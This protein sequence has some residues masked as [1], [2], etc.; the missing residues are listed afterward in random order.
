M[1]WM[2]GKRAGHSA[3]E[4]AQG[5]HD[6]GQVPCPLAVMQDQIL[7][8]GFQGRLAQRP[9]VKQ[10]HDDK[11]DAAA[12]G[13]PPGRQTYA[14]SQLGRAYRS[15]APNNG[16]GNTASH[17]DGTAAASTQ[18]ITFGCFNAAGGVNATANSHRNRGYN[19]YQM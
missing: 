9:R 12:Q 10:A 7:G 14:I 13:K 6:A 1:I 2:P 17:H 16:T 11:A 3:K 8:N 4:N 19:N 15:T 5:R 18:A